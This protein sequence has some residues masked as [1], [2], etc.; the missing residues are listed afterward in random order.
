MEAAVD[1]VGA[2]APAGGV[3]GI[4]QEEGNFRRLGVRTQA[5]P[6][7]YRANKKSL[8]NANGSVWRVCVKRCK[9]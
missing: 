5:R 2:D 1:L 7:R 6:E 3:G 4:E 9:R 8:E